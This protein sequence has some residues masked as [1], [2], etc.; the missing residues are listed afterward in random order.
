MVGEERPPGLRRRG[1]PLRHQPGD[2]ALG[3]VDAE[4]QELAMDSRG[5]PEG[6]RRGHA[7]DQGLDLGVDGRATSGGPAG[8]LGPVLAEATPLPPQDGVGSHDH[9][10]LPPAG[11]DSG[12]PD[13]EE[14]IRRAESGPGHR[15][16]VDGE[17]LAQGQVLE[18]ELAVAA[19]EEGEEPK[20]VEQEGDH[21]A[22]IVV[23][24]RADRSTTCPPDGVLARD[25]NPRCGLERAD[26]WAVVTRSY[27]VVATGWCAGPISGMSVNP[28]QPRSPVV[29]PGFVGAPWDP[30]RCPG[31]PRAG[32]APGARAPGV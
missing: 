11:P 22:G 4:L 14:A 1:A 17:L 21:R 31:R 25:S 8:E 18:G 2:G 16:L 15:S 13:P 27:A 6:I 10:G 9:E 26:G 3:H 7:R 29:W 32:T 5:A 28:M 19:E 30:R 20:Q 23:R 24:I 12:Q